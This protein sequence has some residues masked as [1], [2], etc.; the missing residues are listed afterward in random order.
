MDC[1]NRVR[2]AALILAVLA[3]A[4]AVLIRVT[5]GFHATVFDLTL[6]SRDVSRPL[7]V[8]AA[9][10]VAFCRACRS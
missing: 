3:L 4:W 5:G 2:S 1:A 9:A 8:S 7:A 10:C 6:T